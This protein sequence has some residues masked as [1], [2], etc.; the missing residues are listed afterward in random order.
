MTPDTW[1]LSAIAVMSALHL[2]YGAVNGSNFGR[3][4]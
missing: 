3:R 2:Y 4:P 1:V